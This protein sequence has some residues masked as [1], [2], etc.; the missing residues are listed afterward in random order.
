MILHFKHK[1]KVE[2]RGL[3]LLQGRVIASFT[4]H[5]T[6]RETVCTFLLLTEK[7]LIKP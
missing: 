3:K 4:C 6:H 5:V 7:D 1:T 2:R